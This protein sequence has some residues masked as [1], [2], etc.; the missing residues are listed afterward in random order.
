MSQQVTHSK[1]GIMAPRAVWAA[2]GYEIV[3]DGETGQLFLGH[4]PHRAEAWLLCG[5]HETGA[6]DERAVIAAVVERDRR[7]EVHAQTQAAQSLSNGLKMVAEPIG[8]ESA[9]DLV[10]RLPDRLRPYVKNVL[11]SGR[12]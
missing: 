4:G 3:R 8:V 10:R 5:V 2:L 1:L 12:A 7:A 6:Y 9:D 11:A